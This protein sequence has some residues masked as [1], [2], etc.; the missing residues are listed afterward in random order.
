MSETERRPVSNKTENLTW[1][2]HEE[3]LGLEN[4]EGKWYANT[5]KHG[6]QEVRPIFI[7]GIA[8]IYYSTPEGKVRATYTSGIHPKDITRGDKNMSK[9]M[10]TFNIE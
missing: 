6:R 8:A 9:K 1:E 10:S 7:N 2:E 4:V 3:K 5:D